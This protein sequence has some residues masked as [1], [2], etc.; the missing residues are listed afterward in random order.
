MAANYMAA[1]AIRFKLALYLAIRFHYLES[2]QTQ[3]ALAK[4]LG[5]HQPDVS[6]LLAGELDRFSLEWLE[7]AVTRL[8]IKFAFDPMADPI[9]DLEELLERL[10]GRKGND[11]EVVKSVV[12]DLRALHSPVALNWKQEPRKDS[13]DAWW[14]EVDIMREIDELRRIVTGPQN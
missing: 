1:L 14:L 10:T 2:K 11:Q 13:G 8:G 7:S 9:R 6:K 12:K 4:K 3:H 5:M